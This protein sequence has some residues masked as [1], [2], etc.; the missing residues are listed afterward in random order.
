MAPAHGAVLAS[1]WASTTCV[2]AHP[3]VDSYHRP[4]CFRAQGLDRIRR[5]PGLR[6]ALHRRA[7]LVRPGTSSGPSCASS[8]GS[9]AAIGL[10]YRWIIKGIFVRRLLAAVPRRSSACCCASS[11]SCSAGPQERPSCTSA[12][13]ELRSLSA[14]SLDRL[15]HRQSRADH[16]RGDVLR[17]L[18]RLSRWRSCWAAP[19]SSSP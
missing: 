2:N 16:V 15:V 6:A 13:R 4:P 3:R 5:L 10:P 8:E 19:A 9:D 7:A 1:G 11:S 18:L 14:P 17:H 12:T